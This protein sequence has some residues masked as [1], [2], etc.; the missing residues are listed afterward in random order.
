MLATF[1]GLFEVLGI[2]QQTKEREKSLA[3]EVY[4]PVG[5][6]RSYLISD[7]FSKLKGGKI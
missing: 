7:F 6:I 5:I 3:F 4:L 2:Y 1:P